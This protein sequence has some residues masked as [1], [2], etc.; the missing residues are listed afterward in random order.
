[1]RIG[2]NVLLTP[3]VLLWLSPAEQALWWVF[4]ALGNLATLADFG[5][6]PGI[7]R[8][9]SVLWAGAEDF[10]AEGLRPPPAQS[11]P[12]LPRLR[13]FNITV[14]RLYVRLALVAA[15]FLAVGASLYLW[16]SIQASPHPRRLWLVWAFYLVAIAY[17]L[18]TSHWVMAC[19]GVNQVRRQQAAYLW[20]GLAYLGCAAALLQQG[21][22]LAAMVVATAL[23]G[24]VARELAKRA[25]LAVVP[26]GQGPAPVLDE[27]MLA[28][29]WPNARKFGLLSIGAFLVAN[30]GVL[31][32]NLFLPEAVTASFGLTAQVGS[33]LMNFAS[34]WLAVKWPEITILR[35][36][37]RLEEMARLFARRL[38]MVLISYAVLA[39][40]L[41]LT[42]NALLAWK[43][44]Q[45]RLLVTPQLVFFLIYLGQQLFYV[46]FGTLAYTEN[47]MPFFVI[48]LLTGAAMLVL[49][50]VLTPW[51]GLW[52]LL[53]APVLAECAYS[54]WFT[55][56]RGFQSQPMNVRQFLRAALP[57]QL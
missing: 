35:A 47:V 25:Y 9:Y 44:T 8:V 19:Q 40:L 45:T 56:R 12:N 41:V 52:G 54:T 38:A 29:L 11:V 26:K 46:Q 6:G 49:T 51:L 33:F 13:Q 10:D 55:V 15:L 27:S 22:G 39:V 2:A 3:L 36:Q 50:L 42:G 17:N 31:V 24:V 57:V 43:G 5:F 30:G 28:R 32:S 23:R 53:L 7:A 21:L 16:R 14:K 37:G 18:G 1:L 34:L 48:G 20:S 4:V